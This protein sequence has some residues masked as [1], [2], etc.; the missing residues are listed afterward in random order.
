[1][2]FN[3][4]GVLDV[5][6]PTAGLIFASWLFLSF[7]GQRYSVGYERYRALIK[8][9]REQQGRS[10]RRTL[11]G[12]QIL[13]YKRRCEQMKVATNLGVVAALFLITTI[14]AATLNVIFPAADFL[15]Y[16]SAAASMIGLL[17]VSGGAVLVMI[18]NTHIQQALDGEIADIPELAPNAGSGARAAFEEKRS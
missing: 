11:L 4:K 18:E 5:V 7:L 8:E 12:E 9:Y 13:L 3:L 10:A 6:G 16:V 14:I 2:D 15:K 17:L 1:M